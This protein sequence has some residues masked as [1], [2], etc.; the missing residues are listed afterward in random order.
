M[1]SSSKE[2]LERL[3]KIGSLKP[4][5]GDQREFDGLLRAGRVRLEDSRRA[6]LSAESRFDLAYNASHAFALAALRHHGYRSKSRYIVFQCLPHT[7][8]VGDALWRVLALCHERR[9]RAEY[10]GNIDIN[11]QLVDDLIDAAGKV[12]IRL[13]E[14]DPIEPDTPS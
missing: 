8:G 13:E 3:A 14:L 10:E 11:D 7:L 9:N 1:T 5:P 6:S 12:L 4:E 2:N